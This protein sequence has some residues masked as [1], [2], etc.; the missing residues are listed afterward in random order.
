MYVHCYQAIHQSLT[1]STVYSHTL[2]G[3]CGNEK[4]LFCRNH[5]IFVSLYGR[6]ENRVLKNYH[7]TN[8]WEFGHKYH[9]TLRFQSPKKRILL[10]VGQYFIKL[11]L[12]FHLFQ[13][14]LSLLTCISKY[15]I[16]IV[17]PNFGVPLLTLDKEF[18]RL[19]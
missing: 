2:P 9:N 6:T 8:C 11:F 14:L 5:I 13:S 18:E 17:I 4:S 19:S 10:T 12:L 1:C 7:R 3:V 15:V 16:K